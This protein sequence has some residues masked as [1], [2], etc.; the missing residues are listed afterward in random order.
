[1][2]TQTTNSDDGFKKYFAIVPAIRDSEKA[3]AFRIRHSVYCLDLGWESPRADEMET[4]AY[5]A[6]SLHCLIRSRASGE[7]IACARLVLP[8]PDDPQA[9]L[10]FEQT[11]SDVLD[12]SLVDPAKL[13]RDKIAEISRLAIV[14][15]HRRRRGE[16]HTPFNMQESDFGGTEKNPRFPWMLVGLYMGL[17]AIAEKHGLERLFMLTEPR[18]ARHVNKIGIANEQIGTVI[19]H[20]GSRAPAMIDVR[21]LSAHLEPLLKSVYLD[22]REELNAHYR[23]AE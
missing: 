20:R 14:R 4:D 2:Y 19:E 1:M 22:V 11:C 6:Q 16:E 21:H 15:Q 23:A 13:R 3:E 7:F 18:M 17:L 9:P 10:P 8:A 12:R 5:D